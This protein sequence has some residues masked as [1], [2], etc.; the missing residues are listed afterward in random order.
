MADDGGIPKSF[1]APGFE[2]DG[3]FAPMPQIAAVRPDEMPR[4]G[5][6]D[7]H[8]ALQVGVEMNR[9]IASGKTGQSRDGRRLAPQPR[10]GESAP[11]PF[12]PG[13]RPALQIIGNRQGK[14]VFLKKAKP[15]ARRGVKNDG[16]VPAASP[17]RPIRFS[18]EGGNN[19]AALFPCGSS[20]GGNTSGNGFPG[21]AL[22]TTP[23]FP[24]VIFGVVEPDQMSG[25]TG[26]DGIKP[27][28][29]IVP[30][31][32]RRE[33]RRGR[34][35]GHGL[36]SASGRP[37]AG[38]ARPEHPPPGR[39]TRRGDMAVGIPAGNG[40]VREGDAGVPRRA[41]FNLRRQS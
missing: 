27:G 11:M 31:R 21:D 38:R 25:G 23:G 17:G 24:L 8:P 7:H 15:P 4:P 20:V 36:E 14:E 2:Q 5:M 30:A 39:R 41:Q 10:F 35:Q 12:F 18:V 19:G 26:N 13:P 29:A 32:A 40:N 37:I 22:G 1:P 9:R 34:I 16:M 33:Y 3:R 28:P 6:P